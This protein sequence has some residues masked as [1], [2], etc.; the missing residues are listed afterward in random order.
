MTVQPLAF[1]VVAVHRLDNSIWGFASKCFV[2][3]ATNDAG[4]RIPFFHDDEAGIVFADY[5]LDDR[6]S[7]APSYIHGGVTM[8]VLDEAMAWATIAVAKAFALTVRTNVEFRWPLKVGRP[9][10]VEARILDSAGS[11]LE[12][13]ATVVDERGRPCAEAVATF[14]SMNPDQAKDAMGTE[15]GGDDAGYV[16][17]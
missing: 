9:Y 2:C 1:R 13:E 17:G 14:R 5:T 10:R 7:G 4:L 11:A 8:A 15:L 12:V 16:K 6:F 3:E